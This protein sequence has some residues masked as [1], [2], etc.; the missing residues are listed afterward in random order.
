LWGRS[1]AHALGV[2][3]VASVAT[4]GF[5][6]RTFHACPRLRPQRRAWIAEAREGLR[7]F[8]DWR[9]DLATRYQLPRP[10]NFVDTFTNAQPLNV[11]HL[12]KALQPYAA[13]FGP[14]YAFV[15]VCTATSERPTDFAFER[16]DARPLVYVSFG[17]F[18]NPGLAFFRS[19]LEAVAK[20]EWQTVLV[21]SPG[22]ELAQLGAIP[23]NVIVCAPGSAPQL[24]LL[25][26]AAAFVTH[27]AGG[28]LREGAWYGVPMVA[29]PQTYEQEILSAHLEEQG[30][31]VMLEP[32][33]VTAQTLAAALERTVGDPALRER[34]GALRDASRGAGGAAA[35]AEAIFA[36]VARARGSR[37]GASAGSA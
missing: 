11:V 6:S 13:A 3:A 26:R 32:A 27:G 7:L 9:R 35:A 14:E 12:P 2:P 23:D 36:Y 24:Q 28:G 5:T 22:V 25:E 34:A 29:V 31:G 19:L 17:T 20:R 37:N 30:A 4:A 16:L 8:R 18:H 21:L 10:I 15:G 33:R 1:L